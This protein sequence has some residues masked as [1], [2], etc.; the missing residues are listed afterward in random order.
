M[1]DYF[2]WA[3]FSKKSNFCGFGNSFS[4]GFNGLTFTEL[5]FS[6]K[7]Q[8]FLHTSPLRISLKVLAAFLYSI[9][10]MS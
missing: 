3:L 8:K 6:I 10:K 5:K 1:K 4:E 9:E 2:L 7:S